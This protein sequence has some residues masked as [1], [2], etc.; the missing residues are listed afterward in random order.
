M[1]ISQN[2]L[3]QDTIGLLGIINH[4]ELIGSID[5]AST[6]HESVTLVICRDGAHA[7]AIQSF[8]QV[9]YQIINV[10]GFSL[11]GVFRGDV[12]RS[13]SFHIF[14]RKYIW[15]YTNIN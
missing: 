6:H 10:T 7:P 11:V 1:F 4:M 3:Q 15:I 5:V 14:E 9:V 12:A 2:L 13:V 8:R